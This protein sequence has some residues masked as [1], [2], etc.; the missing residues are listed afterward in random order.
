MMKN[1]YFI[2]VTGIF[3]S[4]PMILLGGENPTVELAGLR[5]VG[6]GYGLNGTELQAFHE[7]SGIA[8]ALVVK[9]SKNRKIVDIDDD[10]CSL[11]EFKDDRNHNLLDGVDWGGF[12]KITDDGSA[13]LIEVTSKSRPSKDA[14]RIYAKGT[15]HLRLASSES[16]EK[17]ETLKLEV[18]AEVKVGQET[19]QVMKVQ[20]EDESLTL[21][22]QISRKFVENMKDIR[23][24]TVSGDPVEIWG[25]GSFTFGNA[26][27]MEYNLD[28]K[29]TP[30][31]LKVEIDLWQELETVNCPFEIKS[32]IGL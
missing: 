24:Y 14:T 22:L 27:Q 16:T 15:I 9:T 1:T 18:G 2:V 23:F 6:P 3:L 19:I 12:P 13:G 21:V 32:G 7:Q 11:V 28:L 17:I 25:R 30:E 8:L 5:I 29:S 10:N 4:M 31:A 26:S 20:L